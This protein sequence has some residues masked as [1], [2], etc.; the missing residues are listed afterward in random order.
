MP[1][2]TPAPQ[3]THRDRDRA[4]GKLNASTAAAVTV[5]VGAALGFGYVIATGGAADATQPAAS[6]S[7]LPNTGDDS[8]VVPGDGTGG[9]NGSGTLP[10]RGG[11]G[12]SGGSGSSGSDGFTLP[13][14]TGSGSNGSGS[15][16]PAARPAAVLGR[17]AAAIRS[18]R[19]NKAR[20]FRWRP[21]AGAARHERDVAGNTGHRPGVLGM[22]S[23]V[24][25]LGVAYAAGWGNRIVPR[26]VT[27]GLH[28]R[29]AILT[30]VFLVLHIGTTVID[31]YVPVSWWDVVVPFGSAYQPLWIGLAALAFDLLLAIMISV[32]CA[33][34]SANG[35]GQ[36]STGA[37]TP[38]GRWPP[39]TPSVSAVIG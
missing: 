19:R 10:N 20:D 32:G 30:L 11:S 17:A 6:T 23:A 39:C 22:L 27:S 28:R 7:T 33:T 35:R 12:G 1:R 13:W 36:R 21:T 5:A 34:A 2:Q 14:D 29:L 26:I 25:M 15:G 38:A 4:L 31:G 24:V 37:P 3:W 16:A 9:S 18:C 8:G